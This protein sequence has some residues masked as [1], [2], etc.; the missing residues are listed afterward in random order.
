[1]IGIINYRAGNLQNI[2]NAFDFLGQ[3]AEILNSPEEMEKADRF[4]VPGV[5]AYGHAMR[6]FHEFHFVDPIQKKATEGYPI[7]GICLGMQVL[8]SKGYEDGEHE[9][10]DLIPGEVSRLETSE[11]VPQMGWNTVQF[12]QDTAITKGVDSGQWYYFVHSF[13]CRPSNPDHIA[14]LTEYGEEKFCSFAKNGNIWGM[15]F[16]PEKSQDIGLQ[17]LSNFCQL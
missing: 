9:G 14:G 7:L 15:Q 4:I 10:L 13:A 2:K 6:K 8:F 3:P 16:H 5:G 17:I 12:T 1:M 11:K